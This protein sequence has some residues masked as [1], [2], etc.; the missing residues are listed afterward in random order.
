MGKEVAVFLPAALAVI[1]RL[2]VNGELDLRHFLSSPSYTEDTVHR[3]KRHTSAAKDANNFVFYGFEDTRTCMLRMSLNESH[4]VTVQ[5]LEA[6]LVACMRWHCLKWVMK[7]VWDTN[8]IGNL[9]QLEREM[10]KNEVVQVLVRK[11]EECVKDLVG[12]L[13]WWDGEGQFT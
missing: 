1:Q 4:V 6:T 10:K 2:R 9:I 13:V 5:E 3:A 12:A 7:W 8:A 11:A